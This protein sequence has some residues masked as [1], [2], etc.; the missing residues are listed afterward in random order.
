MNSPRFLTLTERDS[1][2]PLAVRLDRL[3]AAFSKLRRTDAWKRHVK[4]GVAV[5]E[6][7]WNPAAKTWH[8]HLHVLIDGVFFPH[9][10]LHAEWTR[11]LGHDGTTD[12]NACRDRVRSAVYI[13]KYLAKDAEIAGWGAERI[14][15][16]SKAMHRRRLLATFGSA[17]KVNVDLC[18]KEA[19]KPTLP[20]GS[21]S[22]GQM[23][24]AISA[25][26]PAA[27][28]A[29]PLLARMGIAFRQLFFEWSMPGECYADE[30]PASQLVDFGRW[31]EEVCACI[32]RDGDPEPEEKIRID[33]HT[34]LLFDASPMY[35]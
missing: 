18:D 1:T 20:R 2:E 3:S 33:A 11:L 34:P 12:L 16:F 23:M 15:E 30:I 13:S 9:A 31:I 8:P 35:K 19:E 25:G 4:G 32:H 27:E 10:V 14:V 21:I 28:K 24:D 6:V 5:W 7:K 17:H 26:V 29:A 22:Y